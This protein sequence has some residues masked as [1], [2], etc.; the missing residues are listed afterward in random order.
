M[1]QR[2]MQLAQTEARRVTTL[3]PHKPEKR[4]YRIAPIQGT[5]GQGWWLINEYGVVIQTMRGTVGEA[6]DYMRW[7]VVPSMTIKFVP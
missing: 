2:G 5:G 6:I 3:P 7:F 1:L 4:K